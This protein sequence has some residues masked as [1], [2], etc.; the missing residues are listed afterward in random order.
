MEKIEATVLK[1]ANER[2][3]DEAMDAFEEGPESFYG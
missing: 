1:E 3:I 2:H